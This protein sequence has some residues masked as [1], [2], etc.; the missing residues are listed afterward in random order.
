VLKTTCC[1]MLQ[2]G[3]SQMVRD[4]HLCTHSSTESK[5]NNDLHC[6]HWV[7]R[8]NSVA[9]RF[10]ANSIIFSVFV[11]L[12]SADM[13]LYSL[14]ILFILYTVNSSS[15]KPPPCFFPSPVLYSLM[16]SFILYTV[17]SSSYKPPPS[18]FSS[19]Q[20]WNTLDSEIVYRKQ[21]NIYFRP[22]NL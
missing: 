13:L 18:F 6:V 15:Y 20:S 3:I 21:A 1:H 9:W 16:L 8:P 5:L 10:L 4:R 14:M 12:F 19:P 7:Q 22:T 17:N 2:R 11:L